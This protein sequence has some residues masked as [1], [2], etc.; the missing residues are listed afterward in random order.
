MSS[1][2]TYSFVSVVGKTDLFITSNKP[3]TPYYFYK[4][5]MKLVVKTKNLFLT[6]HVFLHY[7]ILC[8]SIPICRVRNSILFLRLI[9]LTLTVSN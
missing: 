6:F 3:E 1:I 4:I 8:S 9:I 5:C 2:I 7:N